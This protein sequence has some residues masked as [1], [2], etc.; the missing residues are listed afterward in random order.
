MKDYIKLHP[1]DNVVIALRDLEKDT[2]LE[3]D[4]RRVRVASA[5]DFGHKI[6]IAPIASGDKILK[7][8]LPIG[9]A[10]KDIIVGEHVHS[11]NLK[12]DYSKI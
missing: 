4:G 3:I 5:I 12:S 10:M 2:L 9:S 1:N 11:Q 8:G 7:Y 6:A